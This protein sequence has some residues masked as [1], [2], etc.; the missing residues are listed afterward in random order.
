[1]RTTFVTAAAVAAT[2][3]AAEIDAM[4]IPDF[5]AG[6]IF[7]LTGDNHLEE[8]ETCYQGSTAIVDDVKIAIGDI[9]SGEFIAGI[10][11]IGTIVDQFP[12]ALTNCKNMD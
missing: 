2:A 11:E 10:K 9:K 8:I 4:A 5:I 6:F 3:S 12:S 1:M 7:G